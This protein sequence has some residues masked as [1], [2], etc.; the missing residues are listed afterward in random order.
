[1][2]GFL[3][4]S[5]V[6]AILFISLTFFIFHKHL[7]NKS[8]MAPPGSTGWPII[9]EHMHLLYS[10]P[11]KFINDR[12][13]K[14]SPEVF[15]TSILGEKMVVFCG[16]DGNRFLFSNDKH[17]ATPWFPRSHLDPITSQTPATI[18][19]SHKQLA[20]MHR[21]FLH[22]ILKLENVKQ[23]VTTMDAMARQHV[24]AD[25]APFRQVK[26]YSLVKKYNFA[27]ACN[28]FLSV[29]S[30]DTVKRLADA[31]SVL[32]YGLTSLPI[33][34][35]GTAYNRAMKGGNMVREELIKII[36][37]KR[38]TMKM[39]G[40]TDEA[41]KDDLLSHLLAATYED[42]KFLN[43]IEVCNNVVG[44]LVPAY[45]TI[46]CAL[47]FAIK[48]LAELPHIYG[49]VYKEQ[50]EIAKS[51]APNELLTWED[52]QKMKYSW[53]VVCETI[54]LI[55]P[56]QGAFREISEEFTYAG[57]TIPKGWK[58]CWNFYTTH[59]DPKYFPDPEKLDPLR[60]EGRGPAP[61]TFV[62]FGGGSRIWLFNPSTRGGD[63]STDVIEKD[64]GSYV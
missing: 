19:K 22:Q 12:M 50:I 28:L 43:D 18:T 29:Q 9:G 64:S 44:I 26:A 21:N 23:Y 15:K 61:F 54:R 27:V 10:G 31:Y 38:M 4:Y 59:K 17:L 48:F 49:E 55:P 51:K 7:T 45:D 2:D 3:V 56:A 13:K 62:P 41:G 32:T 37:E 39:T 8:R 63:T 40:K 1:M 5:L 33:N 53:N 36:Q 24:T 6:S 35:P 58:A 47:T 11:E 16:A 46:G 42:G 30:S 25:W 14:Y 52:I 60:F 20:V 34:L 57:F